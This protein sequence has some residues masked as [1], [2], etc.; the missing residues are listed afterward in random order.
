MTLTTRSRAL[1][2]KIVYSHSPL[3]IKECAEEF[4][5][6]ERTVKYDLETIRLWLQQEQIELLSKPSRGIW[7]DCT[8]T[9]R[10]H[11]LEKLDAV[12]EHVFLNQQGRMR[13]M[14]IDLLLLDGYLTIGELVAK[15]DV[16]RNTVQADLALADQLLAGSDLTLSRTRHGIRVS[17]SEMRRRA[18]LEHVIQDLLDGN[19]MF[20]IVQGVVQERRPHL[21]FSKLLE[22]FLQPVRDLDRVFEEVGSLVRE[23]REKTQLLLTDNAIIGVFIRLCIVIQRQYTA[24]AE[25]QAA[26]DP[27][28][29]A[30]A[31]DQRTLAGY[32]LSISDLF[33][34]KL[35]GLF[36][37]L[38]LPLSEENIRYISLPAIGLIPPL[39]KERDEEGAQLPDAF[40]VTKKL[41]DRVSES[42]HVR[43]RKDPDLIQHLHAHIADKLNKYSYGVAEPNP[44]L[45]EILRSYRSMFETVSS[46]CREVFSPYGILLSAS[47]IAYI[48][49][50]F[51]AAFERRQEVQRYRAL[52]VCG[53]GRGTS[54]LLKTVIENEIKTLQVAAFCSV[55]EFDKQAGGDFDLVISIFPIEASVPVVVVN[56]IPDKNDFKSIRLRLENL[57]KQEDA[58]SNSEVRSSS[59][60]RPELS[61]LEQKFQDIIWRG[62]ELSR[63]IRTRFTPYLNEERLEGLTLHLLFMMNRIAFDTAYIQTGAA[64]AAEGA[65]GELAEELKMLLSEHRIHATEGEVMA[66]LRYFERSA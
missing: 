24:E 18:V 48:V 56:P 53:T 36:A 43:F 15:H 28:E 58:G 47:D 39:L 64:P 46:A 44:L 17:G 59:L 61:Y 38:E 35:T 40:A 12:G 51:Q 22:W 42:V 25:E 3:R 4:Q 29:R 26:S 31:F 41:I 63:A 20:Q 2:K 10:I 1:L 54:K 27:G 9:E 7:I 32:H 14:L 6:S 30:V 45:Q 60:Q 57:E 50:H 8:D 37:E 66:I 49:L 34:Q 52:V 19:D 23:I 16:S 65:E 11:L 5:V 21:H 62:F 55:M 13:H 33:R